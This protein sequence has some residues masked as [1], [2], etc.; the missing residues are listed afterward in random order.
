M[1]LCM[2]IGAVLCREVA[3][4]D[5]ITQGVL[6]PVF[7][8]LML[9]MTYCRVDARKIRFSWMHLWLV[10]F[11]L[12]GSV[13]IYYLLANWN[14]VIAQGAMICVLTPVAMAAVVIG[15]ML[16]AC[17]ETMA[18]Y[19]LL[20]N[21]V[22]A[23]IAPIMLHDFG[24]GE[25]TMMQIMQRVVPLLIAPFVAGQFCRFAIPRVAGWFTKH[26]QLSFYA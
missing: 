10:A 6:T 16:G 25:C 11:Q 18:A 8:F 12:V 26:G 14:V 1:P 22:I 17:I 13:V 4:V 3:W 20:C 23:L 9:F 5:G 15:G 19:S 2:V 7:I 24:N 21:F